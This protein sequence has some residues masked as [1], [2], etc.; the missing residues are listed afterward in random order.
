MWTLNGEEMASKFLSE[1][2]GKH[3]LAISLRAF[4]MNNCQGNG[5]PK[6]QNFFFSET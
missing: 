2:T 4:D 5:N 1:H 6:L 3:Y